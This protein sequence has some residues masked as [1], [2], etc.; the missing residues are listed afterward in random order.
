[1]MMMVW[2][3]FESQQVTCV[4]GQSRGIKAHIHCLLRKLPATFKGKGILWIKT[5]NHLY[6]NYHNKYW[7]LF[8]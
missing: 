6:N 3:G 1:M 4:L 2:L 5:P 7:I 8:V